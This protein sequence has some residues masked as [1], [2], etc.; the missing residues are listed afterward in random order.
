MEIDTNTNNSKRLLND[1][2]LA[3]YILGDPKKART[4]KK[5]RREGVT[6]FGVPAPKHVR[7]TYKTVLTPIEE[8]DRIID[9]MPRYKTG[10]EANHELGVKSSHK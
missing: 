3:E 2:E 1:S 8:A 10:T 5:W 6:G 9:A 7:P 4:I